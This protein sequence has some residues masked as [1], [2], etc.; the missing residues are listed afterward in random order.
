MLNQNNMDCA[1]IRKKLQLFLEDL[2]VEEEY[3]AFC[4]HIDTCGKCSEYVRSIGALS[5][6]LW[7]LGKVRVPEDLSST[8]MYKLTHPDEKWQPPKFAISK[9]HII[10]SSILILLAGALFFGISYFKRQWDSLNRSDTPTVRTEVI[11][12]QEPPNDSEA[13]A[14]LE[15][16]ETIA[17]KLGVSTKDNTT[18]TEAGKESP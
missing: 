7:K 3:K 15:K 13:R 12:I 1:D 4:G 2:L 10:A 9:K 5:N 6:Q 8:I 14:L 18:R 16:L 17:T 11:R